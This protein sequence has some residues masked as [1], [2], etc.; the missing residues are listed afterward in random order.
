MFSEMLLS[1]MTKTF[2]QRP[3]L[4]FFKGMVL[5]TGN[6]YLVIL[7]TIILDMFGRDAVCVFLCM[8]ARVC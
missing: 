2:V 8:C 6:I 5:E 4:H 7:Y 1:F 3:R